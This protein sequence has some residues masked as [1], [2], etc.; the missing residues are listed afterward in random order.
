M[1]RFSL[2]T[3]LARFLNLVD[4]TEERS[5]SKPHAGEGVLQT[6]EDLLKNKGHRWSGLESALLQNFHTCHREVV[7]HRVIVPDDVMQIT[8]VT[9]CARGE[10]YRAELDLFSR[11]FTEHHRVAWIKRIW[12]PSALSGMSL[13]GLCQ[14]VI[15]NE[16]F[17]AQKSEAEKIDLYADALSSPAVHGDAEHQDEGFYLR[18]DGA[19]GPVPPTEDAASSAGSDL[20]FEAGKNDIGMATNYPVHTRLVIDDADGP[21]VCELRK[22]E[23]V[24][25]KR[26]DVIVNARYTSGEHLIL[27]WRDGQLFAEDQS[28]NG[29]A[30][31]G[32]ALPGHLETPVPDKAE[33]VFG[34]SRSVEKL[35]VDQVARVQVSYLYASRDLSGG[36]TPLMNFATQR[37][38][39][40]PV[41]GLSPV[42]QLHLTDKAREW[43]EAVPRLPCVIGREG[44]VRISE[45]NLAVSRQHLVIL[46][47][48]EGGVWV[49]N[50]GARGSSM[51]GQMQAESF[52]LPF[53]EPVILGGV[54]ITEPY[55]PV[56]MVVVPMRK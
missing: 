47:I 5:S 4:D 39:G 3:P 40:T 31:N 42:V 25:G 20:P 16:S 51:N 14:V 28:S 38:E 50:M 21:R 9:L 24:L 13:E 17:T 27:R 8:C 15:Q 53:S 11:E 32:R 54:S 26:G 41:L 12:P 33:I 56:Q 23:Y 22:P 7:D 49:Q 52:L 2:Y 45:K 37:T 55:D 1:S 36:G 48:Q 30:M 18:F 43:I 10:V 6:G 35:A 29:T 44:D 19:W 34:L 46:E